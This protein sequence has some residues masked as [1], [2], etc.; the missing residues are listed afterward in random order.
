MA[1]SLKII[2][3]I[4]P[5][6]QIES[7]DVTP[8]KSLDTKESKQALGK[9]KLAKFMK[10]E[11]QM[12]KGVFQNFETP[13]MSL[14]LQIRKYPGHFFNQ[15]M[16]DGKEYEVPLYVA[17]HLNGIDVTA[18]HINGELGTCSYEIHS[19]IV[20][21]YGNPIINKQKRK[22]RFGFQSTQFAAPRAA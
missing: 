20:D 1:K 21:K 15:V 12:V 6:L 4:T 22:R 17:R 8:M 14:P 5:T 18:E 10:E 13:G 16:E 9:E 3:S 11:L 7:I 19:H 2:D